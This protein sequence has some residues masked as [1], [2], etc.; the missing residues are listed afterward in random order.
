MHIK[1][2]DSSTSFRI[3]AAPNIVPQVYWF[4]IAVTA[5]TGPVIM[6]QI[7]NLKETYLVYVV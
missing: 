3:G 7:V 5:V 1:I 6:T 4:Q 2:G